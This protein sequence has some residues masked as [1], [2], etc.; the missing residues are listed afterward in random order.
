VVATDANANTVTVGTRKETEAH[1][2]QLRNAILHRDGGSVDGVR[3]RYRSRPVPASITAGTGRDG[4]LLHLELAEAFAGAAP[5]QTA[6]LMAGE[7][8]V[9]HGTIEG[10]G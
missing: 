6:V 9:G 4:E 10:N 1:S 3:L 7:S 5:G 2:V 8:I